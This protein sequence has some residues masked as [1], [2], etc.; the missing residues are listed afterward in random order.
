MKNFIFINYNIN[1][2]KIYYKNK[3]YFFYINNEKIIII[4]YKGEESYIKELFELTNNLYYKNILVNTFILNNDNNYF[5]KKDDFYIVLLKVNEYENDI[6]LNKL[7]LFN[8]ISSNLKAFDLLK[9]WENEID[10]LE[11]EL[12]EYNK[13][14]ND[15]LN[16]VDYFIGMGENAIELMYNYENL[17]S[18]NNNSIGHKLTYKLFDENSLNNPFLFIKANRMYDISNYIKYKFVLNDIDYN[19]LDRIFT[20]LTEYEESYLFSCLMYPS[21]Y[22]DIVKRVL[23][24]EENEDKIKYFV[25]NIKKYTQLL[26]YCQ[27]LV[28][29]N[30][31][32]RLITWLK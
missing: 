29:N 13:E 20:N 7:L 6:S 28:K 21:V 25:N 3:N 24:K 2:D 12:I 16:S 10:I 15:I 4:K 23:L 9:E 18:N 26:S 27:N 32:I 5:T 14:Y 30:D 17:I 8:N 1:V 11:N 22:F 19:E 31:N